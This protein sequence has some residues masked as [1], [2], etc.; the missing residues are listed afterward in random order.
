MSE[1][2]N[3]FP[4]LRWGFIE[5]SAQWIPWVHHEAASRYKR[6]GRKLPED[7]FRECKIFV[8]CQTDDDLD[9]K[10]A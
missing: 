9:L 3:L 1:L 10:P 7:V 4:N 5:A 8:T 2:P 6:A